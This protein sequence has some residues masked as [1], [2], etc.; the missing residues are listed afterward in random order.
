MEVKRVRRHRG[1]IY[2]IYYCKDC[3]AASKDETE[4]IVCGRT[5]QEIGW[6]E[7]EDWGNK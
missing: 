4:C 5:Q 3:K 1:M 2:K 7:T 6:V